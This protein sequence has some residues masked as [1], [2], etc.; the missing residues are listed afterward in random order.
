MVHLPEKREADVD[1]EVGTTS[2]HYPNTN[3]RDLKSSRLVSG[4]RFG[5]LFDLQNRVMR[6][7]RTAGTA[8]ILTLFVSL[9]HRYLLRRFIRYL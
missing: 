1:A 5:I 6:T 7:T 9:G 4:C 8:P 2:C 3:G